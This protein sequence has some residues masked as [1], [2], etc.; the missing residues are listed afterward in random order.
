MSSFQR[1]NPC[2]Q[3]TYVGEVKF[4]E[5]EKKFFR[6]NEI[7]YGEL[8]C[9]QRENIRNILDKYPSWDTIE[10]VKKYVI[11]LIEHVLNNNY[12]SDTDTDTD[13]D[14]CKEERS[15]PIPER[16]GPIPERREP[17]PERREPIPER[18][19][20]DFYR[21]SNEKLRS[22]CPSE[23]E[24]PR[25]CVSKKHYHYQSLIFHPDKNPTCTVDATPKFQALNNMPSCTNILKGGKGS[26]RKYQSS[27]RSKTRRS[28]RRRSKINTKKS[29]RKSKKTM[30]RIKR[31]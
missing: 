5:K 10:D 16:R 4:N 17:I 22:S 19:K 20:P 12:D 3:K 13:D 28:S 18:R 23:G 30:R 29:V 24:T 26:S 7:I 31:R 9:I 8:R 21:I 27:R 15:G 2:R 11:G 25:D 14:A 6:D 1:S